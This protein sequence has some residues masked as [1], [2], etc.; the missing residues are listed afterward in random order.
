M[1][2]TIGVEIIN[3]LGYLGGSALYDETYTGE[4]SVINSIC[5]FFGGASLGFKKSS[6]FRRRVSPYELMMIASDRFPMQS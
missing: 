5:T 1:P 3:H 6:I 2:D 4:P